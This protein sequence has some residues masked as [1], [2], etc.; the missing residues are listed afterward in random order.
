MQRSH[1]TKWIT[2]DNVFNFFAI[3]D[4]HAI[5][6]KKCDRL[7]KSPQVDKFFKNYINKHQN[8]Y[9]SLPWKVNDICLAIENTYL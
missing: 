8:Y 3:K 2:C 6:L 7:A 1:A 4:F 5:T 9:N